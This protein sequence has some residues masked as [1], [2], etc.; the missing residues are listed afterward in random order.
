MEHL[1][2]MS[3]GTVLVTYRYLVQ[4]YSEEN[5][6]IYHEHSS[7]PW[8][9]MFLTSFCSSTPWQNVIQPTSASPVQILQATWDTLGDK[10]GNKFKSTYHGGLLYWIQ[11]SADGRSPRLA[12]AYISTK[13]GDEKSSFTNIRTHGY[14]KF[15][16]R[17]A[18]DLNIPIGGIATMITLL[19]I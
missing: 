16:I 15:V 19:G 1:C 3:W 10:L 5:E 13:V 8:A 14:N 7:L 6:F 17:S 12:H 2:R 9:N 18:A 4:L 11:L